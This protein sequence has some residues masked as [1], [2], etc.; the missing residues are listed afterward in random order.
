MDTLIGRLLDSI[1]GEVMQNTYVIFF[2]DNGTVEW[3]DPPPP[4][5]RD[6]VKGT[7]YQGGIEVPLIVT[8]PG[9]AAGRVER[10]LAHAVDLFATIL[11]LAEV[12]AD[13]ALPGDLAI[14]SVSMADHFFEE[15]LP[16]RRSW[17]LS[18][19]TLGAVVGTAIRDER[20]KL[21][22]INEREEFYDLVSAPHELSPLAM[23]DLTGAA[24]TSYETLTG[25][26]QTL[27]PR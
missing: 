24:R 21:V 27:A 20:Y 19:G 12:D 18:E 9:I 25:Q 8:G 1:P 16:S 2:G 4:R 13:A 11:E 3:D 22:V 14:D 5:D 17:V 7:V 23:Q 26:L 6:R 10:P 15:N